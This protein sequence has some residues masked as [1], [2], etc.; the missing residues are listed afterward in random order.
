MSVA[1]DSETDAVRTTMTLLFDRIAVKVDAAED[2]WS[3]TQIY[4]TDKAK[5]D[6]ERP[7]GTVVA[8]GPGKRND[9][10]EPV[11]MVVKVG[12]RVLIQKYGAQ[13]VEI[14]GEELLITEQK[15]VIVIL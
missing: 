5:A 14:D 10:G 2:K 3:G 1:Y 7:R 4:K 13:P 12:D 6:V 15:Q 9:K 8:V 11:D